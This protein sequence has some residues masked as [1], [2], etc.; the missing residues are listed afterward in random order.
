MKANAIPIENIY[1]LLCYAWDRLPEAE[2]VMV[3]RDP[4]TELVDLFARVLAGGVAHLLKRGLDRSY[5]VQT[6]ELPG[7]RGRLELSQSLQRASFI[8][9]HAVCTFDEMSANVLHN[10]IIKTTMRRL[11][12]AAKLNYRWSEE[13]DNLYRRMPGVAEIR[14]TGALFRRVVLGRNA[15][16]YRFPLDVCEVLY[17]HLLVDERSGE[18]R[19]R[20]FTRHDKEMAR[21]FE[22]FLF[23][24]YQKEQRRYRVRALHLRWSANGNA[25]DLAHLPRMRTDIVLYNKHERIVID[26]KYYGATL[27]EY[28]S[29]TT[30]RSSHLYQL[31]SY[32]KHLAPPPSGRPVRGMLIYPK[33]TRSVSVRAELHGHPF[34]AATIDLAQPWQQIEAD[35]LGLLPKR[36]LPLLA[37]SP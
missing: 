26:A 9:A 13:L 27:T 7:I 15:A 12:S 6:E 24:F 10:Q 21:L 19:F 1:Y 3:A 31:F 16:A 17:R 30:V 37:S 8:H 14:L 23:R 36:E 4:G 18:T 33:T 25:D 35:L 34:L 5:K 32:M 29:K 28:M 22:R 20:D 11:T 2:I